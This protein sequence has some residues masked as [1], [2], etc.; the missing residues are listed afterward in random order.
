MSIHYESE[1]LV[2]HIIIDRPQAHNAF[3]DA[4]VAELLAAWAAL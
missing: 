2:A 1:G 4:M 3:D